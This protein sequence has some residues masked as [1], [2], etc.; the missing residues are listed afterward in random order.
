[1]IASFVCG[2]YHAYDDDA[3]D[4]DD[5]DADD[6]DENDDEH[7]MTKGRRGTC[8]NASSRPLAAHLVLVY[9]PVFPDRRC[10][11]LRIAGLLYILSRQ[12]SIPYDAFIAAPLE[13]RS[14]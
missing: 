5:D 1:M 3:H 10:I 12:P 6:D 14:E 8:S 7:M 2:T 9:H 4:D 13:N 11:A